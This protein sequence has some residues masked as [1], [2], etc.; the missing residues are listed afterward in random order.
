MHELAVA[1]NIIAIIE[2]E[3]KKQC[4]ERV[5]S[6]KLAVGEVSGVVPEC[7]REFF[8]IASRG[9][10]AEGARLD[11]YEIPVHVRCLACGAEG[12]PS[13]GGCPVCAS[14]DIKL[15]SGRE[16]FVDSIEVE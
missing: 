6:I 2:S 10:A 4:F 3:A 7:L 9:T 13:N 11:A 14:E 1:Q 12:K 8:P 16:F 15:I 5:V